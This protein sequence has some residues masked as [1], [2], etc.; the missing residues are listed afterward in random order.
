MKKKKVLSIVLAAAMI[1]GLTA[2][3]GSDSGS[4]EGGSEEAKG[5]VYYLNFK[6][7]ADEYWQ[8]LAE[9]YTDETGVPV[10]VLTAASGEYEK[11]LKSEMAK[12]DAPT[13]FQVNGPVGL[14]SWK[15]YCYDLSDSD[16][17]GE[18]TDDS[19]ALMDGDKMAGIAYVVENYGIIYNKA[20]LEQAGYTADDITD[21][22]SFKEVVEDITARKDELGFS[23]FTSAGMD[24]SSDWR[25]KTHLAN[26]P[27]YYEYKDEGIDTTDAI[28]GTY[29][30]NY[31]Q[32]WD[33]YINN[34]TCA[35]TEISTK[36]ADDATAEFVTEEAVFYQNGTWEYNNIAD[37]GDENL[38]ILPIYI[39]VEG[40]ENQ[41]V[42]TGTENY[43]CVNSK[44]SEDDIQAT[45]DFMNWCVTS[46][47]GVEAMCSDMGF[48]IPFPANLESTNTLVNEA[49]KYMEE[50]KTPVTW[51]F[52]TMPSEEWKNGVGSALTAYAADQTDANWDAVVSAFVDGW[53]AEAAA[54][55]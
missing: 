17:A 20:L 46:D 38:G 10:T 25:F 37:V 43:W 13:L 48:V 5:K 51:C 40:E 12:T 41:G 11:T 39:G 34:A 19:F 52:S 4:G 55:K 32:I 28:K 47:E 50:G 7:E 6:P 36:T 22:D 23:A 44:A 42:C 15:D 3:C 45:L 54:A 21:F 49:N 9:T 31:R 26:L 18:L 2:G 33:L 1:A 16:I 53:A 30:D 14:A 29:L 27:I 35:P 24:G 8:E